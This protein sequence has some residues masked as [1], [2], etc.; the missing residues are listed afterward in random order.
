MQRDLIVVEIQRRLNLITIANG[1]DF[2]INLV[3]RNPEGEPSPNIMPMSN[4]FEFPSFTT[5]P[6]RRGG[7]QMPEYRQDFQ[8]VLEHWYKSTSLGACSRDIMN[9]LKSAREVVFSDG[10]RL[11]GLAQAVVESEV[12]RVYRPPIG[13][14]AVGIGQVL[15]ILFVED[16][17][18]L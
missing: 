6:S 14:N 2:D 11:G 1:H 17:N 3:Y 9:Y 5:E 10:Q 8:V 12:S 7:S 18:N 4:I 16:F 15:N 13:S